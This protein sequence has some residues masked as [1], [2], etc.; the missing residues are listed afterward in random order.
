TQLV[1]MNDILKLD[2]VAKSPAGRDDRVFELNAGDG[3]AEIQG[4][5][6]AIFG[7]GCHCRPP[8]LAPASRCAGASAS[9]STRPTAWVGALMPS[10]DANVTAR[11]TGSACVRYAP[12]RNGSP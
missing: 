6:A 1:E 2:P 4:R 5:L 7:G 8:S 12:G 3:H 10:S 11:S 9:V